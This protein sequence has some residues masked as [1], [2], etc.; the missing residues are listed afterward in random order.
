M[1][2]QRKICVP[3]RTYGKV[4]GRPDFSAAV[5]SSV[6]ARMK[7]FLEKAGAGCPSETPAPPE[8]EAVTVLPPDDES[9]EHGS[10]EQNPRVVMTLYGVSDSAAPDQE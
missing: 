2:A 3:H 10:E 9:S 7:S 4:T 1:D 6:S 8:H 5:D